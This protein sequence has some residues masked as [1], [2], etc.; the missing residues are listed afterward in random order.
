MTMNYGHLTT[1]AA[2]WEEMA[3]EF[4][5]VEGSYRDS[6]QKITM[7]PHWIGDSAIAA[8]TN[9][10]A[11]R[12]EYQAAQT[13]AKA[14]G[15]LLRDAH[16]QFIALRKNLTAARD[17]AI[18]AGMNVSEQGTV[19]VDHTKL[20]EGERNALRHEPGYVQSLTQPW[21]DRIHD[22]VRAVTD[23]DQGVKLALEAVTLD[24][25]G[26]PNDDTL[27]TGFNGHAK[28]DI[29]LYEAENA[30]NIATRLN[31]GEKISPA[32]LAELQRVFRDNATNKE[33]SQ[34]FL[35]T[36]GPSNVIKFSNQMSNFSHSGKAGTREAYRDLGKGLATTLA[37]ATHVPNFTYED[38]K[39]NSK[40]YKYGTEGYEKSF[41]AWSRTSDAKFYNEW[42]E[43]LKKAGTER[44]DLDAAGNKVPKNVSK[45]GHDQQVNGYQSLVTLMQ[46]GS[47]YSPQFLGD[48][49][50]DMIDAEKKDKNIWKLY[51]RFEGKDD[52]WFA[53][54]PVDGILGLMSKNPE[55]A[56]GYLD[57]AADGGNGRLEHL[58]KDRDWDTVKTTQWMGNSE[59]TS[60]HHLFEKDVRAG[61][62]Q[63]LEAATRGTESGA[64]GER[65]GR[66]SEAEARIMHETINLIDYGDAQGTKGN[67]SQP[68][69][70]DALLKSDEY[71]N[72]RDPLARALAS[73]APD[74]VEIITGE[75]AA[76]KAGH[77]TEL[78][79]GTESKIQNSR[80][81]ILRIMRGLSDVPAGSEESRNFDLLYQAQQG[82]MTEQLST[83]DYSDEAAL[84]IRARRV[85]EVYGALTSLGGDLAL[86]S[87]DDVTSNAS[88][89]R[90]YG[91]HAG[92]VII[93]AIPFFGDAAQRTL[94]I[95]LNEWQSA[96]SAEQGMLARG[97]LSDLNDSAEDALENYFEK[98]GNANN[99]DKSTLAD[100]IGEA[101]QS[102]TKGRAA[103]Y[104]AL[105]QP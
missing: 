12:Y 16:T 86:I 52:G 76:R 74:T 88:D 69:R 102:Y 1:A 40:P 84:R 31:A 90:F 7:G 27:G 105:V 46:E 87:G 64:P 17:A 59:I 65:F 19:T 68:G 20:T 55:A 4:K 10:A 73:Y 32:E 35:S 18:A 33:F 47:G 29:E 28:G 25:I 89:I 97:R 93:G 99:I 38:S 21:T 100:A 95:G 62:G 41:A 78:S 77:E 70:G 53:N 67:N 61:L 85:G 98:W 79:D 34:S 2:K 3:G 6:V 83:E 101:G 8:H 44:Y 15:S 50:D 49:A 5:K 92:G 39:G 45:Y 26:D 66:H 57:S 11:T 58:L 71:A 36:L 9:F 13:Q 37:T 63:A 72:L 23:H 48:I 91:Y 103:A 80:G 51:G 24:S 42:R 43:G 56:T 96:V 22:I 82:Y 75:G 60:S 94:D 30:A 54:D 14:T 104:S 81:S